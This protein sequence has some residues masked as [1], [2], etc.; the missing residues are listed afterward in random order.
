MRELELRKQNSRPGLKGDSRVLKL[1]VSPL[2]EV[3]NLRNRRQVCSRSWGARC[4]TAKNLF[5]CCPHVGGTGGSLTGTVRQSAPSHLQPWCQVIA[6][7]AFSGGGLREELRDRQEPMVNF[8]TV[9][10]VQSKIF[11]NK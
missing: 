10:L 4:S 8:P 6:L 1:I 5:V 7:L 2:G 11:K 3:A 9:I